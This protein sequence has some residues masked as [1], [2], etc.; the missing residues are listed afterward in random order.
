MALDELKSRGAVV[1]GGGSGIGRGIALAL[2]DE[3][4]RVL[5]A[6]ING[7]SAAAVR[8]EIN[9]NGGTAFSTQA[10]ATDD[11]SLARAAVEAESKLGDV[12]LLIHTVGVISDSPVTDA[13]DDDWAWHFDF[14]VMAAVR[15]VRA[16]L[17]LLRA[18]GQGGHIV[19]TSSTA[20]VVSFPFAE[21]G[22]INIGCY[23]VLKHAVL[24]YGEVLGHELEQFGIGVSVLCPGAVLTNL[25]ETSAANRP[26][27]FGGPLPTPK[28]LDLPVRMDAEQ[29]GRIVVRGIRANRRYIFTHPELVGAIRARRIQPMLDDLAFCAENAIS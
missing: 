13:S 9:K 24:G 22:G 7:D 28:E 17:P 19:I 12:Q 6:D 16:F 29:V 27:R 20:G 3:G 1:V 14:N 26:A 10:D 4:V 15:V 18:H 8:D 5:V 25:D 23:T 21:T 11:Q 2:A